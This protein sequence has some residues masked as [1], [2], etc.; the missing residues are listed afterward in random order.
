MLERTLLGERGDAAFGE[1]GLGYSFGYDKVGRNRA[2]MTI[3]FWN[4]YELHPEFYESLDESQK[5]LARSTWSFDLTFTSDGAARYMLTITK[6]G[7]VPIV[8]PGLVD[9]NGDSINLDE[10]PDE[11]LPPTSPPQASGED[12]TDV[13]VAAA[14]T[15]RRISGADVQTFLISDQGVQSAA[16]Q[17]GDWLE[18]KDGRN[19]R[20]MIVGVSQGTA[21]ASPA[22]REQMLA[23]ASH[24]FSIPQSA[25]A[26]EPAVFH[27]RPTFRPVRLASFRPSVLYNPLGAAASHA[28]ASEPTITQLS[29]VCMQQ[30]YGIPTRGA[31]YF[32]Q[33]KAAEGLIQTCQRDCVL[34]ETSNIQDCA[35]KCEE[36]AEGNW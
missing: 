5:E 6:E 32:S 1:R 26:A 18:P 21:T 16:Y 12:R 33:P 4:W 11:V 19:Q 31:R 13:E 14:I 28:A 29:V 15:A 22:S 20:M 36:N 27:G 35:W 17:P 10:F 8:E 25:A 23:M 7:Q 24:D 9:F 3:D 30:G 2:V 34:N